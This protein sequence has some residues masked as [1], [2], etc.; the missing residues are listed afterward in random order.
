MPLMI[1]HSIL[2][3]FQASTTEQVGD[4]GGESSNTTVTPAEVDA[5]SVLVGSVETVNEEL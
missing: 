1:Q 4:E 2:I 3:P 5:S